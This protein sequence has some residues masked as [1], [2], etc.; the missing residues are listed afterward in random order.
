MSSD[1]EELVYRA[2]KDPVFKGKLIEFLDDSIQQD[3]TLFSNQNKV[4]DV[5]HEVGSSNITQ[6]EMKYPPLQEELPKM[7]PTCHYCPKIRNDDSFLQVVKTKARATVE[8]FLIHQCRHGGTYFKKHSTVCRF[9]YPRPLN[10]KTFLD[11]KEGIFHL[12]RNH[13]MIN[14]FNKVVAAICRCNHDVK[15]LFGCK[16]AKIVIFYIVNY[17]MKTSDNTYQLMG[18]IKQEWSKSEHDLCKISTQIFSTI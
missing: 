14:N 10:P 6:P 8:D 17:I 5:L 4:E 11:K 12:R 18:M 16:D 7:S 15:L 3:F 9:N 1:L 2:I 13:T